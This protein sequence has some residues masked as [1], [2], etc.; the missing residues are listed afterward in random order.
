MITFEV[1]KVSFH[2]VENGLADTERVSGLAGEL[3]E[4]VQGRHDAVDSE[5]GG[6]E[7][8]VTGS[9]SPVTPKGQEGLCFFF[10]KQTRFGSK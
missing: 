8:A 10:K 4:M 7:A 2:T 6:G 3:L 5:A 9:S 1:E